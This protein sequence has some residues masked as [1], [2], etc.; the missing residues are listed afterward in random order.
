MWFHNGL[1]MVRLLMMMML[2]CY[3]VVGFT[4]R[5][6]EAALVEASEEQKAGGSA[7][8]ATTVFAACEIRTACDGFSSK[9][10]IGRGVRAGRLF[11]TVIVVTYLVLLILDVFS[12]FF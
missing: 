7:S 4:R 6:A 11:P 1:C 5:R 2:F 10:L 9:K 3:L 12:V 8:R